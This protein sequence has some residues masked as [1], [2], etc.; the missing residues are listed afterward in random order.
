VEEQILLLKCLINKHE[1]ILEKTISN[2]QTKLV[3]LKQLKEKLK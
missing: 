2:A 1:T 3:N